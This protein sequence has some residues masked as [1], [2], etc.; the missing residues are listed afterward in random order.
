MKTVSLLSLLA[1][2]GAATSAHAAEPAAAGSD[3]ITLSSDQQ[4]VRANASRDV[5]LRNGDQH[6]VVRFNGT[7]SSAAISPKLDFVTR[8]RDGQLCGAGASSLRTNVQSCT[9][10]AVE[11]ISAE[12]FASK[13]RA[14]R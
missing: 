5:L 2:A 10:A 8:G 6:F 12:Q 7:C 11:P 3:C 13:A 14:R 4:I 9:V 1:L